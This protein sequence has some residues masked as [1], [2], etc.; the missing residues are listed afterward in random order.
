MSQEEDKNRTVNVHKTLT[1]T[2]FEND[3]KFD[4]DADRYSGNGDVSDYC[5]TEM[6]DFLSLDN[7]YDDWSDGDSPSK[8]KRSGVKKKSKVKKEKTEQSKLFIFLL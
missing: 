5:K 1:K 8:Q 2:A 3:L 4:E 7:D 6:D